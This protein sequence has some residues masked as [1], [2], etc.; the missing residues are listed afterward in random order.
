[1]K[2]KRMNR[3]NK[4]NFIWNYLLDRRFS[5]FQRI[6]LLDCFIFYKYNY[7]SSDNQFVPY[8][9]QIHHLCL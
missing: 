5:N 7:Y 3:K 9:Y 8:T 1:M 4:Q 6:I 2:T